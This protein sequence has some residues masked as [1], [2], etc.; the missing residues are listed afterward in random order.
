MKIAR[1]DN[2]DYLRG[3]MAFGI[4]IY[5]YRFWVLDSAGTGGVLDLIGIYGVSIFYILSGLTL[6]LV[7]NE[8]MSLKSTGG[9]YLKRIF[10][11]FPLFWLSTLLALTIINRSEEAYR[12][13]INFTGAFGFIDPPNSITNGGW[14]IGNELVFY[15]FFPILIWFARKSK[16]LL[17]A[18]FVL[19]FGVMIYFAFYVL[20][21]N[22][23]L[24]DQW[25]SYVNPLNQMFLFIGGA[26]VGRIIRRYRNN[27][28]ATILLIA[29]LAFFIFY[30]VSGDRIH[31]V[32]GWN[33]IFFAIAA[34]TL[35]MSV[36]LF[37]LNPPKFIKYPLAKLGR[38]SYSVYLLHAYIFFII[39]YQWD[40]MEHVK[41]SVPLAMVV[42]I[43]VSVFSYY[44][45]EQPFIKLG[46][47]IITRQSD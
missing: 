34:F 29:S 35:T 45:L 4:M 18:T 14:S 2:L 32:T 26:L 36:F 38:I 31:L 10:R 39:V 42:T 17:I 44:L 40:S 30:P 19:S 3:L 13:V 1:V 7:Y 12:L 20:H 11:I 33:R 21:S 47:K 28:M 37:K 6:Y 43:I 23:L 16:W 9:F 46:R 25:R 22:S 27:S 15:A 24:E 8:K 5:H 41:I